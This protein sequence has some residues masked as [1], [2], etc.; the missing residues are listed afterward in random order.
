MPLE[1]VRAPS[2]DF[3]AATLRFIDE[4][5]QR[6][7]NTI[8]TVL[9]PELYVEH[10]WEHLL[11]NQSALVLKGRLLFRANTAVTSIPYRFAEVTLSA[12][13]QRVAVGVGVAVVDRRSGRDGCDHVEAPA[14]DLRRDGRLALV[15]LDA[16][17]REHPAVVGAA[18]ARAVLVDR[19]PVVAQ[20]RAPAVLVVPEHH[21]SLRAPGRGEAQRRRDVRERVGLVG[22]D[23]HELRRRAA[24]GARTA[25]HLGLR[26]AAQDRLHAG[27][28]HREL[29]GIEDV[30]AHAASVRPVGP[31]TSFQPPS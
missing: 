19:A 28:P 16:G 25:G 10:W 11:H 8:V 2:G 21:V 14:A 13:A 5:E 22:F 7:P 17:C 30:V 27:E 31:R 18:R 6:W 4:L 1:I 26:L 15:G 24:R 20:H 29:A 12:R 9:I 3:T 23:V